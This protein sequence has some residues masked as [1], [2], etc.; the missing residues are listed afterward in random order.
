MEDIFTSRSLIK[1][2]ENIEIQTNSSFD[3]LS[4]S[5]HDD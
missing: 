2:V 5:K 4:Q 3:N 1:S